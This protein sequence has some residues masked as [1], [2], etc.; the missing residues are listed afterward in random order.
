MKI[1]KLVIDENRWL[2]AGWRGGLDPDYSSA[3]K[4][5]YLPKH[6]TAASSLLDKKTKRMC[7][8]GF[9]A[10]AAGV[11]KKDITNIGS[12]AGIKLKE[13][14]K[15]AKKFPWLLSSSLVDLGTMDSPIAGDLMGIN[16]N[17]KISLPKKRAKIKEIFKKNGVE[18]IFKR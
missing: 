11:S 14:A 17:P 1:T 3:D 10:C 18:V 15:I 16:D 6:L 12:P 2:R 7:C 8:L 5:G 4:N 13:K 9:A